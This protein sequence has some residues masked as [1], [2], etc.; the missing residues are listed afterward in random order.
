[1]N[2]AIVLPSWIGDVVMA[3]PTL[4]AL[5]NHFGSRVTI[6]GIMRPYVSKVLAG[7]TWLDKTIYYDRRSRA[8][9]LQASR[10]I[11]RLREAKPDWMI[12]MSNS[13]RSGAIAW[14]SGSGHR[15]GYVRY[16]RGMLLTD[17]IYPPRLGGKLIPVSAVDYYL[18]LAYYTGCPPQSRRLELAVSSQDAQ[19]AAGIWHELGFDCTDRVVVLNTGGAFGSAKHWP[20]EY[21]IELAHRIVADE[22]NGVLII[23]FPAERENAA[24]IEQRVKH[25]RVRSMARQNLDLGITK[26]CIQ[27]A[28]AMVTADSGPRHI[29]TALDVPVVSLFGPIDPRWTETYHPRS[30]NLFR[31]LACAPCGQR[32]CSL[33]HH[34]CMRDLS[35]DDVYQSL[36]RLI[37]DKNYRRIGVAA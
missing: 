23:C 14:L 25:P 9:D 21:Y 22:R 1:M 7:T 15:L 18:D 36:Q 4:R 32:H 33:S 8:P 2:I 5:R 12:L 13:F 31:S 20:K 35:V 17:K 19:S 24:V 30:I 3:T 34:R 16:G 28:S 26:A 11:W 27:R 6:T 29:A 37:E 10:L